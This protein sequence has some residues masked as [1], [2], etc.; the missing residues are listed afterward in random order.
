MTTLFN[1][2][3][4]I[5]VLEEDENV[6][7]NGRLSD[8]RLGEGLHRLEISML[9]SLP[10]GEIKEISGSMP[11]VPMEECGQ[12]LAVLD[13][14]LGEKIKPGFTK[15]VKNTVGSKRGCTHLASLLVNMGNTS[16]Q[17]RGA[18]IRKHF[19]DQETSLYTMRQ[20]A[21]DLGLLDSCVCW[22]EDGPILRR[23]RGE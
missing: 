7:V 15:M 1:R 2:S 11:R 5:E 12:G 22:T 10:E 16:V 17:G 8:S 3:I 6:R 20:V 21:G 19:P 18:F 4:D 9:V 23:W 13:E 14:V